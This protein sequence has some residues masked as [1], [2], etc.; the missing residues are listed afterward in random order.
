MSRA[1]RKVAELILFTNYLLCSSSNFLALLWHLKMFSISLTPIDLWCNWPEKI[2]PRLNWKTKNDNVTCCKILE[3]VSLTY[4]PY[5]A[6]HLITSKPQNPSIDLLEVNKGHWS[7]DF[8]AL[9]LKNVWPGTRR[10]PKCPRNS[11]RSVVLVRWAKSQ[12]I[13][14]SIKK[15]IRNGP[16]PWIWS[17]QVCIFHPIFLLLKS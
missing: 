9:K 13:S 12:I 2:K 15:Y 6:R 4:I 1:R 3:I 16:Q 11:S 17:L 14:T 7:T 8:V 10:A 5:P